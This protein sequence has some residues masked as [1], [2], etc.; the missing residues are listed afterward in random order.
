MVHVNP[1]PRAL[2]PLHLSHPMPLAPAA[3]PAASSALQHAVYAASGSRS[4]R[5]SAVARS[6]H[7]PAAR[8]GVGDCKLSRARACHRGAGVPCTR[9]ASQQVEICVSCMHAWCLG[10]SLASGS[11]IKQRD[12]HKATQRQRCR[13]LCKPITRAPVQVL[14]VRPVEGPWRYCGPYALSS[15]LYIASGYVD[16]HLLNTLLPAK[17]RPTVPWVAAE[18]VARLQHRHLPVPH[19]NVSLL[20]LLL[21]FLIWRRGHGLRFQRRGW[22]QTAPHCARSAEVTVL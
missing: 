10:R 19:R 16:L 5:S 2:T 15:G 20:L 3:A 18:R 7:A 9:K 1:K 11:P 12:E 22:A 14:Q 13:L 21:L 4:P 17:P 8:V 6:S